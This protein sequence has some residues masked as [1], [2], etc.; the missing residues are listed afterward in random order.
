MAGMASE[1]A[2]SPDGQA[3]TIAARLLLTATCRFATMEAPKR[4]SAVPV[5]ESCFASGYHIA[6]GNAV[7]FPT[8]DPSSL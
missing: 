8:R 4:R 1:E 7:I 5:L 2:E 3:G 6:N